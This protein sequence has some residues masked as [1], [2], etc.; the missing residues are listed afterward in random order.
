MNGLP[1]L[2][3]A[4]WLET[5]G[6]GGFALSTV[7]GRNARRYH[8]LVVAATTP[9][10][11]RA[12]LLGKLEETLVVGQ[13]RFDLSVNRYAGRLH[14]RGDLHLR[15]FRVDPFPTWEYEAG[16][17]RLRRTFFLVHGE[18]TAVVSW[19]LITGPAGGVRLEVRPLLAYRDHHHLRDVATPCDP[20]VLREEGGVRLSPVCALPDLRLAHD[21][22]SV[23]DTFFW[24]RGLEYDLDR[25]RGFEYTEDLF[26]PLSFGWD[27]S[28]RPEATLLATLGS[29]RAEDAPELR[30]AEEKRRR[31]VE[32]A[33]SDRRL[34][35]LLRAAADRF[36]VRRAEGW[37]IVAGYPWFTDWG[38]DAMIA[39]PG[40]LLATRRFDVA[41]SVLET[42]ARHVDRGMVPN[43]FPDE[44]SEPEYNNVDAT[45]WFVEAVRAYHE[46]TRD[47]AFRRQV[48]PLLV[49]IVERHLRGTRFGIRADVDALLSS[50][51]PG[52]QL[53]WMD[54]RVDGVVVTPRS[55]KP[56]EVQALWHNALRTVALYAADLGDAFTAARLLALADQARESF[57][58]L[59][60][61]EK[62]GH[63]ADVVSPDGIRDL[64]F[65]PNQLLALS[66]HRPLLTGRRAERVLRTVEERL[67]TPYGLR[68]L[69][70][71]HPD[72]RGRFEGGPAE[73]DAAYHQGTVWPWLLGPLVDAH[74]AV[75]GNTPES[76]RTAS[77]WLAPLVEHLFG[78]GLGQLPE[79]FDG[80]PPHRPGGCVAQAWSVGEVLR[81]VL[82]TGA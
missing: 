72:Y 37:T 55:G 8:G 44:G 6:L 23:A 67:L 36:V 3:D 38:R 33:G 15:S 10:T 79:V 69:D 39:L 59:F 12:V 47:D 82:R 73:R 22:D 54:A 58:A 63:L 80:D 11:G 78:P 56:V 65:R 19:E 81:A 26:S 61:D 50:G 77:A 2:P 27:L 49:E 17:V 66:L 9:P 42:F 53:T 62:V 35:R 1:L 30:A 5:N 51:E 70:P 68:T 71:A 46:A 41:R 52:Q 64:S 57:G 45:L 32:G 24:Y 34:L 43:R 7:S 31:R 14:P 48:Y 29:R 4:E 75:R 13:E 25:E 60:W 74:L 76:R 21:A 18:D 16:G 28:A 20:A 40:L